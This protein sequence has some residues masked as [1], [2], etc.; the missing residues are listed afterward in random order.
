MYSVAPFGSTGP[1]TEGLDPN[2]AREPMIA[3]RTSL[4]NFLKACVCICVFVRARAGPEIDPHRPLG[5]MVQRCP[6]QQSIETPRV[7]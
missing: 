4:K 6:S 3:K 2:S 7:R 5:L 1:S